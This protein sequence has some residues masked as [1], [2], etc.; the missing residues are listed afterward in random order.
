MFPSCFQYFT[1]KH[2][3]N[4][5]TYSQDPEL[6]DAIQFRGAVQGE[7]IVGQELYIVT[8]KS[9]QVKVYDADTFEFNTK[10]SV[11]G[12]TD[13]KGITAFDQSLF[14]SNFDDCSIYRVDMPDKS[15][16]NWKVGHHA[17]KIRLA[18]TKQGNVLV[19]MMEM[20]KIC[21]YTTSGTF[22]RAIPLDPTMYGP[23]HAIHLDGDRF[24]FSHAVDGGSHRVCIIDNSG[25]LIRH[26]GENAG[27]GTGQLDGP[28]ELAVDR[29]GFVFV[30]CVNSGKVVLL[31]SNLKFVK[32]IIPASAD[33]KNPYTV[34]LDECRWN[35]YVSNYE[36]CIL[37]KLKLN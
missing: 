18:M 32:D 33:L 30:T 13:P 3:A 1:D 25:T 37:S 2:V 10:F 20:N 27:S 23:R 17:S 15:V 31:D 5:P 7:V 22:V 21:E 28:R 19:T 12:L 9:A 34:C 24:L 14:I 29:T 36:T 16:S 4:Q 35:L 11:K 26:Y 6:I 8:A